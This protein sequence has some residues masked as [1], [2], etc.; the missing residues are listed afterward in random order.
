MAGYRE[1]ASD[2]RGAIERGEYAP[3]STIPTLED[4]QATYRVNRE[5]ARRAVTALRAEGLVVPIRRRGTVVRDRTPIL[6]TV[7]RH[8]HVLAGPGPLG[9]WETACAEQ[10]L[11]GRTQVVRVSRVAVNDHDAGLLELDPGGEAIQRIQHMYVSDQVGQLQATWIPLS[12]AAGTP[13][14]Q[15]G[16]LAGGIYRAL[17]QLGHHPVTARETVRARMPDQQEAEALQLDVGTPV[18]AVERVT[19]STAGDVLTLVRAVSTGDRVQLLYDQ[20]L[21]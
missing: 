19:R 13:L 11:A 21:E 4:L 5:T 7:G 14:E 9:P 6:L 16:K 18:L 3:G 2:L 20:H 10:G 15:P 1:I 8:Q 12:I 17:I